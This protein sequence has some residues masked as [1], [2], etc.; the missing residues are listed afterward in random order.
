M[1]LVFPGA[2]MLGKLR[3]KGF[4]GGILQQNAHISRIFW[5]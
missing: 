2:Q 1:Q 4:I 5:N 3:E